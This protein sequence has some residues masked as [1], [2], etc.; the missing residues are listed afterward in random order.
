MVTQVIEC[1]RKYIKNEY[2]GGGVIKVSDV[3]NYCGFSD[4]IILKELVKLEK[5]G[6]VKIERRYSCPNFHYIRECE[7]PFCSECNEEYPEELV[8]VYFYFKPLATVKM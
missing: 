8:N 1:I 4:G 2:I 3:S 7:F 6:E 5:L